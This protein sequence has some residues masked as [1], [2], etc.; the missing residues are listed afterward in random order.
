LK[1]FKFGIEDMLS[2][3]FNEV[4]TEINQEEVEPQHVFNLVHEYLIHSGYVGTLKAFEDESSIE[5]K[6]NND[7]EEKKNEFE[8]LT[9]KPIGRMRKKTLGPENLE[10][11]ATKKSFSHNEQ[12]DNKIV[13]KVQ[14]SSLENEHK[15]KL[16]SQEDESM[17]PPEIKIESGG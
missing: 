5:L 15:E 17:E 12:K 11:S 13:E 4:Y 10:F 8:V 3:H 9:K 2:S 14:E 16:Q 7:E 6:N 1:P